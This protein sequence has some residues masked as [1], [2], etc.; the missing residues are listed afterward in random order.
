MARAITEWQ[1]EIHAWSRGRGW[2]D[3][4]RDLAT[5]LMLINCEVAEAFE[6]FRNGHEPTEVYIVPDKRGH[7]KPEGV[8][9]ELADI[10]IRLLDTCAA[11]GIDLEAEMVRK[12][13]YNETR[14][15]RHGN[16][17]A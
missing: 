5:Y 1:E 7:P 9:V 15:Y 17:R 6:E 11:L 12:M 2:H 4:P 10:A 13:A 3:T 16:K 14:E 8:P